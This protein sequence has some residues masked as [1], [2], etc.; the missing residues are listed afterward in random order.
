M[1]NVPN[2][3]PNEVER[4]R[5][6]REN[7]IHLLAILSFFTG[8]S[9]AASSAL[10]FPAL[11][12]IWSI[13]GLA[14]AAVAFGAIFYF[15]EAGVRVSSLV[16]TVRVAAPGRVKIQLPRKERL[17]RRAAIIS[18]IFGAG[19]WI[20]S[21]AHNTYLLAVY[22][23]LGDLAIGPGKTNDPAVIALR[24]DNFQDICFYTHATFNVRNATTSDVKVGLIS[25]SLDLSDNADSTIFVHRNPGDITS[26]FAS[27]S[28]VELITGSGDTWE[29]DFD[30]IK[31]HLTTLR[32]GENK[33]ITIY[34]QRDD[35]GQPQ[36][37][38]PD[39][40]GK[41]AQNYNGSAIRIAGEFAMVWPNGT[42]RR[43]SFD[44]DEPARIV[45][46]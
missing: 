44:V 34:Q 45:K 15:D 33:D 8:L 18:I 38:T 26:T 1:S 36:T 27:V 41:V 30:T 46:Q 9:P 31:D 40:D 42:W 6:H 19:A 39:P 3:P 37:C 28:G 14:I 22:G 29:K 17:L 11:S 35:T 16:D 4:R 32:R 25:S 43:E 2:E 13:L 10:G 5:E 23:T 21:S 20:G 7:R 12:N 24:K